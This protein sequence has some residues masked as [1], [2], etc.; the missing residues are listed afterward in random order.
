[1]KS[2]FYVQLLLAMFFILFSGC[3]GDDAGTNS[4][5]SL[6]DVTTLVPGTITATSAIG[7]G[8][9]TSDGGSQVTERGVCWS[10]N[11]GPTISDN[12]A[13][14]GS[15]TGS[16]T[17]N[18]TG[19]IANTTYFVRAYATNSSGTKY[20]G[21]FTFTA[22]AAPAKYFGQTVPEE[23]PVL[24]APDVLNP[25]NEFVEATA[26]SP[27]G[28]IFFASVGKAD[29]SGA[30]LY[31]SKLVNSAWTSFSAAPFTAGFTY[32][33]EPVFSADGNTL[34]FTGK[35]E[36]GSIDLWTVSYSNGAWGTPVQLPST[37]NS[38]NYNEFRGSYMNNGTFYFGSNR[39]GMMQIYKK[40]AQSSNAELLGG[41]INMQAYEGD[42][43]IAADGHFIIFHSAR[44][45]GSGRTDLYVSFADD[46]G[47]WGTPI[48][49]G[50]SFNSS[51][52][53]YGAHLSSDGKYLFYTRHT[54]QA[55][56]IYWV[57]VSA[58]ESLRYQH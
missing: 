31:Y 8:N 35:K 23:T 5:Q 4:G 9:V 28:T 2:L 44:A 45:G 19:L 46:Q 18:I 36:S 38:D 27:D 13:A 39:S 21:T 47:N 50:P 15:G 48:N 17:V 37:I 26:L 41:P 1:M 20:G 12:K 55:N 43:C 11:E 14:A 29:Y 10:K 40:T 7:G 42:P 57:S 22:K 52:D 16:F 6:P 32:S 3:K 54:S 30:S 58:I 53:E 56:K 51:S 25:L 24:F 34:T 33:N 49:L